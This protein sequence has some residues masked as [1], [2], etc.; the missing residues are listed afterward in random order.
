MLGAD[1][2]R[3]VILASWE[4]KAVFCWIMKDVESSLAEVGI[5]SRMMNSM[6]LD[7]G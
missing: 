6:V 5:F 2:E 3:D 4:A 7:Y 1:C